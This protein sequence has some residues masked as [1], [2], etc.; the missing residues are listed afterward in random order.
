MWR[1]NQPVQAPRYSLM[2]PPLPRMPQLVRRLRAAGAV[3]VAKTNMVEFAFSGIGTKPAL[4][5]HRPIQQIVRVYQEALH[6]VVQLLLRMA[7]AK[8]AIGTDTGDR[9]ASPLHSADLVGF[10]AIEEKGGQQTG[11]SPFLH[12]GLCWS[13][14]EECRSLRSHRCR[15]GW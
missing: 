2:R 8:I 5:K 15:N 4:R 13:H 11:H 9:P 14:C 10:K 1:A 7:C 6:R 12:F 3:I